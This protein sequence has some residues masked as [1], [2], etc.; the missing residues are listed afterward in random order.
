MKIKAVIA[1]VF[2]CF[3]SGMSWAAD[4]AQD[5]AASV[6]KGKAQVACEEVGQC[7]WVDGYTRKDE[8]VV[9]GHCRKAPASKTKEK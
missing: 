7:V 9:K 3:L 2:L 4:Q 6:C 5:K 1:L 8:V